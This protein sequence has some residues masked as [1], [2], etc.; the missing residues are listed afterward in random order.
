MQTDPNSRSTGI[1]KA[2]RFLWILLIVIAVAVAGLLYLRYQAGK[3]AES[4]AQTL[5]QSVSFTA[6]PVPVPAPT[7]CQTETAEQI[8]QENG[9]EEPEEEI[10]SGAI[11]E[12]HRAAGDD[13]TLLT[14][15]TYIEPVLNEEEMQKLIDSV[16]N[17]TNDGSVIGVIR[18]PKTDTKLPIIGEWSSSL[19]K[20]SVCRYQGGKP[21]EPGN[22]IIM[23]HNYKSGAHFGGLKKLK[24]G[25]EVFLAGMDG[26]EKRYVVYQLDEVAPDDFGALTEQRGTCGVSLMTCYKDGTNRLF[27]RCEQVDK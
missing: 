24:V 22:L 8:G 17:K 7:P 4:A 18:I 15:G 27:V 16:A 25:D 11:T 3:Q 5:L 2:I 13:D 26:V 20:I 9:Q 21:N 10:D 19:L 12:E 23:G 14:G 1:R 6:S